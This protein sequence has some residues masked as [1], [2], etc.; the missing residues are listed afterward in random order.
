MDT[1]RL[2]T[3]TNGGSCARLAA[4]WVS[5][6]H[7]LEIASRAHIFCT[8][9]EAQ[10][11]ISQYCRHEHLP[12][13]ISRTLLADPEDSVPEGDHPY[14]SREFIRFTLWKL[15]LLQQLSRAEP[16]AFQPLL[17]CDADVVLLRDPQQALQGET[18]ALPGNSLW[19]QSDRPDSLPPERSKAEY[20]TGVIF[21]TL[22]EPFFWS[23]SY[24]WLASRM[25]SSTD[26][27]GQNWIHDQLA[28]NAVLEHFGRIP[29]CLSIELFRNGAQ[30]WSG[31]RVLLHANWV[32]GNNVKEDRL[33]KAGYWFANDETLKEVG[34]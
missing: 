21:E 3:Q 15:D 30:E 14:G 13:T 8:D 34:L 2:I 18:T 28:A 11:R 25:A 4:N 1:V 22:P 16:A 17:F 9:V 32:R 6:L 27:Y 12:A 31:D 26:E 23:A 29:G 20:S 5:S 24:E 33:R 7:A 19:F 10:A